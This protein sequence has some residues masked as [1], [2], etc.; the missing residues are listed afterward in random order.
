M[1]PAEDGGIGEGEQAHQQNQR[2]EHGDCLEGGSRKARAGGDG[3]VRDGRRKLRVRD[4]GGHQHE[5]GDK[6][7]DD[8]VPEGARHG[9]K[10]LTCGVL[11][12]CRSGDERR[13][14]H[15][16]LVGEDAALE[17]ELQSECHRRA[18]STAGSACGSERAF[19]DLTDRFAE[20]LTVD[21][22][23]N[24]AA[25]HI[26]ERHNGD[27]LLAHPGNGLDA[28]QDDDGDEHHDDRAHKPLRDGL[29]VDER[30]VVES[31]GERVRLRGSADA[32]SG[33]RR[34]Q[35]EQD[36][37]NAT[38]LLVLEAALKRIHRAAEH[39][40]GVVLHAVLHAD[41][42]LG[43]LGGNAQDARNPHPEDGARAAEQKARAHAD[44]VAGAD[45][46]SKSRGQRAELS[47][48]AAC[49]GG[50]V[51][52][53][54]HLD[55]RAELSLDEAGTDGHEDVRE[56][57]QQDHDRTPHEAVNGIDDVEG[58]CRARDSRCQPGERSDEERCQEVLHSWS[59]IFKSLH[60]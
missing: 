26:E 5:A 12:G 29:A 19:D 48:V 45:R 7:H 20:V 8:G 27:K 33:Q 44:N 54:R 9:N 34:E 58:A 43:V 40:A 3:A 51:L 17:A 16:G 52:G 18:D 1:A 30:S 46:G 57:Q 22:D 37:E 2:P 53:D 13:G 4:E 15:A 31:V 42:D 23:D 55:A 59:P 39:L 35:G 21:A 47:D 14:A 50:V 24:Q 28:A 32:E 11:R 38:K 6:A 41:E 10:R 36:S 25:H 56:Q 49:V 60:F